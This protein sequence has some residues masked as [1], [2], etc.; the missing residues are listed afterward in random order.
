MTGNRDGPAPK[1]NRLS[2]FRGSL[3]G[4]AIGDSIG[5]IA[6][7]DMDRWRLPLSDL[8]MS[9]K[10]LEWTDDTAMT[11][12]LAEVLSDDGAI[13]GERLAAR[14]HARWSAEPW[15]GYAGGPP[16]IFA[17]VEKDGISYAEATK[18]IGRAL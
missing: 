16:T 11:L 6:Q 1:P 12:G 13:D 3:L 9:R 10:R 8:V 14:F 18:R 17:L 7:T 2:R 15:R 4:V 5:E